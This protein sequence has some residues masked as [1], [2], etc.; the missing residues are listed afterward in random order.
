AGA[1][2]QVIK[3]VSFL[4]SDALLVGVLLG[5][6]DGTFRAPLLAPAQPDGSGDLAL[7]DFN[8]DGLIDVAVVDQLGGP[9]SGLSMF[10]G[11][12]D[13]TFQP[14]L[15]LDLA[16]GGDASGGVVAAD[17][18]GDGTADLVATNSGSSATDP[19]TLALL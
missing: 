19:G 11:N 14:S 16:T 3:S 7:G 13:G 12:G 4:A 17:L 5:N 18:N 2:G 1:P 6:G 15:R 8:G 10:F 9:T